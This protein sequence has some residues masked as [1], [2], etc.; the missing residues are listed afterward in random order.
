MAPRI[1]VVDDEPDIRFSLRGLLAD[2]R[3][4][5]VETAASLAEARRKARDEPW[6][7]VI[8][9]E[10]LPDG[11]GAVLLAE[12]AL[13]QPA[14]GRVLMS[15]FEDFRALMVGV[16]AAHIDQFVRKPFDPLKMLTTVERV[17]RD[18][19]RRMPPSV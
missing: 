11:E 9:D 3:R 2:T 1:L 5:E 4:Y 17:L 16:N 14:A 18:R 13:T 19:E 8:S 12:L 6:D 10:R 7:V 15:A